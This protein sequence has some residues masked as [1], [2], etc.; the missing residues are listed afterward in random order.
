MNWIARVTFI[1]LCLVLS[2]ASMASAQGLS[3]YKDQKHTERERVTKQ[4]CPEAYVSRCMQKCEAGKEASC[5]RSCEAKAPEF[6]AQRTKRKRRKTAAT[7]AKAGTLAVG[8]VAVLVDRRVRKNAAEGEVGE[9]VPALKI[10]PYTIIWKKPTLVGKLGG[11]ALLGGVGQG[12]ATVRARWR[13]IGVSGQVS[14]LNDG[15]TDLLEADFG[16]TL[17]LA[18]PLFIFG[19]QPSLLVSGASDVD[20]LY[21]VGLRTYTGMMLGRFVIRLDPMLG[22]INRQWNYH[23]RLGGMYR[24]TP[25]AFVELNYDYRD[26]VDLND[27]DISQARLQGVTLQFGFRFN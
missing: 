7:A 19:A 9:E 20:T 2:S 5:K 23:V 15:T 26:I 18:S 22:Y 10:D 4:S 16:P 21:G 8:A 24:I 13:S 17:Y 27:L 11:G 6:C 1:S 25:R 3:E 12:T 14:Y